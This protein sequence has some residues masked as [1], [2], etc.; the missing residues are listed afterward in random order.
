M[1]KKISPLQ[2][3]RNDI[4]TVANKKGISS[5]D[6]QL[7]AVTKNRST[8]DIENLLAQDQRLFGENRIQEAFKKWP[9]L[10]NKYPGIELHF[11]GHLQT[12]KA[13]E[14]VELFDVVESLDNF[15]LVERLCLE[16]Q[17]QAKQL[18]YLIEI[19][20]GREP[21]KSGIWP[22]DF[23]NFYTQL[24][25]NYPLNIAG[26]MCIPPADLNPNRF[27]KQMQEIAHSYDFK[28]ISM[29]MSDDYKTALQH[30]ATIIRIGRALF[31][32]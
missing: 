26:I 22:E 9:E 28:T 27:F 24:I 13:K 8:Q 23:N 12:N 29:G 3:I 2:K 5:S 15:K 31:S 20:I 25:K 32:D 10:K 7:L 6:L 11:I 18:K 14:A 21:Q 16:E 17:K 30:G 4:L 1:V 19:N